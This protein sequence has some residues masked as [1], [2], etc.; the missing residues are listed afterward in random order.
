MKEIIIN[1]KKIKIREARKEDAEA[2]IKYVN[3]IAGESD[4]LTFGAGEFDIS[5]EDEEK[6]LENSLEK[7]NKL[8]IIAEYKGEIIGNLN[9]SGG[10]RQRTA[11]T[12]EFGISVLEEYWGNKI[13]E[14]LMGYLINWSKETKIVR[15]IN[16]RVR[17][18]NERAISLYRK[19]G[20]IEEGILK[21]DFFIQN[22]FYDSLMMGLLIDQ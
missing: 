13:G 11:H 10:S 17:T 22:K 20:F 5:I 21:R 18:D 9:F 2:L 3:I 4:F 14:E 12:G 1:D 15:K 19:L 16:L 8:F 7:D 6:I